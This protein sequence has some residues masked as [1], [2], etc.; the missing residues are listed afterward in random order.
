MIIRYTLLS[1]SLIA[2]SGCGLDH[3]TASTINQIAEQNA[4]AQ[5]QQSLKQEEKTAQIQTRQTELTP[6]AAVMAQATESIKADE[7]SLQS[8]DVPIQRAEIVDEPE[9]SDLPLGRLTGIIDTGTYKQAI[10]NNQGKVIRLKEGENW[11]G[12]TVTS[13]HPEKIIIRNDGEEHSL[14]LLSEFR[15]PQRTQAELDSMHSQQNT[16]SA[17]NDAQQP[18]ASP[19]AFTEEQITELRSRLL[20]GRE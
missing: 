17:E 13:I 12:W 19:P 9:E 5:Q 4:A 6:E 20:V 8:V 10:I 7:K 3:D 1:I 16:Q 2:L 14:L 18:V 11:Q 15:A